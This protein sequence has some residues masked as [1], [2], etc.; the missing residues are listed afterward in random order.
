VKYAEWTHSGGIAT[1]GVFSFQNSSTDFD[2]SWCSLSACRIGSRVFYLPRRSQGL[3][4][5]PP[6]PRS[7]LSRHVEVRICLIAP[8]NV[9]KN[10]LWGTKLSQNRQWG[11]S[12][13]KNWVLLSLKSISNDWAIVVF[14]LT[15]LCDCCPIGGAKRVPSQWLHN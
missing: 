12:L 13:F 11:R 10:E 15:W 6:P 1:I 8:I 14:S 7:T 9:S 2:E 5:P 3:L 4:P